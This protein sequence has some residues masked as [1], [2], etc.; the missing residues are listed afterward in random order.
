MDTDV[1]GLAVSGGSLYIGGLFTLV[2]GN[3]TC[4]ENNIAGNFIAQ[5]NGAIWSALGNGLNAFVDV[6]ALSGNSLFAGGDFFQAGGRT[7]NRIAQ[8]D[9]NAW[10]PL[11]NGVNGDVLAMAVIGSDLFVGGGFTQVC[12]N[13]ACNSGNITVNHIARW[14]GMTWSALGNGVDTQVNALA[15]SGNNLYVGGAF[16]QVCGD[17]TCTSGNLTVNNVAVWDGLTWSALANGV[18]GSVLA[19]AAS[20]DN[21]Y[22]GGIFV[23]ACSSPA[24]TSGNPTVNHIAAWSGTAWFGLDN[25]VNGFGVQSLALSGSDLYVGGFF[26]EV[27]GNAACNT[28]N[29]T[30]NNL[31]QWD[32]ITWS[33]I[34]NGVDG[35]GVQSLAVSG[36]NLFV[37]GTFSHAC[38]DAAC[39]SGN[40]T[41][42]NIAQW[43]GATWSA[44]GSGL[45]GNAWALAINGNDLFVGGNFTA[46][47]SKPS[48]FF[49][50]WSRSFADYLPVVVR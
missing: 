4:T 21:L 31:A 41:A 13:Q 17:P 50:R 44:L 1:F 8:W 28:G 34:G 46:A 39:T 49:G 15:V 24:C 43:D 32:G 7:A 36:G 16:L 14:D 47:G 30:V 35:F 38:G 26:S 6:L 37:G 20:G 10:M 9:G 42:N 40:L 2:C 11:G 33:A 45:N 25:G 3:A 48:Y 23:Q 5:W 12:G 19:L 27:C 29:L 18:K 22:A